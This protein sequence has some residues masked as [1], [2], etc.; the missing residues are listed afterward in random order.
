M[1]ASCD[2]AYQCNVFPWAEGAEFIPDT[3]SDSTVSPEMDSPDSDSVHGAICNQSQSL[4]DQEEITQQLQ[5]HLFQ[6]TEHHEGLLVVVS[7]K[8]SSIYCPIS[9][10]DEI[11]TAIATPALSSPVM[12]IQLAWPQKFS[13]DS[14]DCWAFLTQCEL[15]FELQTQSLGLK[16]LPLSKPV[17]RLLSMVLPSGGFLTRPLL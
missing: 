8:L 12:P 15:H 7:E 10:R 1:P 6:V 3:N 17:N 16:S 4:H 2:V 13:S 14:G 11:P 5:E 9:N